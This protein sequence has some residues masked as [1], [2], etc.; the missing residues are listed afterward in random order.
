MGTGRFLNPGDVVEATIE[1][2]GTLCNV[3]GKKSRD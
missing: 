2:I 3:V 1:G